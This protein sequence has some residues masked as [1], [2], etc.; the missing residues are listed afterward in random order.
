[1]TVVV[2]L[3]QAVLLRGVT[4]RVAGTAHFEVDAAH[5]REL[6]SALQSQLPG[7]LV[8]RLVR[9][10]PGATSKVPL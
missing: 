8:P 10:I 9:E 2:L 7:Y 1:M 6:H 3:N 4:D 5:A